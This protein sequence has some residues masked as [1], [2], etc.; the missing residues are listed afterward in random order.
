MLMDERTLQ[1]MMSTGKQC[2]SVSL[3]TVLPMTRGVQEV[4]GEGER[5]GRYGRKRGREE[6][7]GREGGK[8][9]REGGEEGERGE[10]GGE[11][12]GEKLT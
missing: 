9:E 4:R 10:E 7:E 1:C 12:R 8:E 3:Q 5:G 2:I 11:E 6:R